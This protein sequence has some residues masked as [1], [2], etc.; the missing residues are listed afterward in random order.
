MVT[1]SSQYSNYGNNQLYQEMMERNRAIAGMIRKYETCYEKYRKREAG[2]L[3]KERDR[4]RDRER[5]RD[6]IRDRL[7]MPR[8]GIKEDY[9]SSSCEK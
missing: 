1:N 2:R 6:K 7:S 5:M 4:D 8:I 3:E 9:H